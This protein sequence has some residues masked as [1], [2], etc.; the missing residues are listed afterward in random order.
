VTEYRAFQD[1]SEAAARRREEEGA[2]RAI[3]FFRELQG[4]NRELLAVCD[5]LAAL[6]KAKPLDLLSN[7]RRYARLLPDPL[8]RV[9][10]RMREIRR[11]YEDGS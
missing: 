5:D 6:T 11:R 10:V 3:E 7:L 1:W 8:R 4:L 2:D 9:R